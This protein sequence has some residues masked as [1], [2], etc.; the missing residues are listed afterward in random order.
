MDEALQLV[1]ARSSEMYAQ[2]LVKEIE[3]EKK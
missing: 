2:K 3:E 1:K